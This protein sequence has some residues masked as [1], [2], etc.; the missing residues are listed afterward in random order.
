[1][2]ARYGFGL[3]A[4]IIFLICPISGPTADETPF[5]D[6][7]S[8][9]G[10]EKETKRTLMWSTNCHIS[11]TPIYIKNSGSRD[12]LF[13][14]F[15]CVNLWENVSIFVIGSGDGWIY[16][17]SSAGR[18]KAI[19]GSVFWNLGVAPIKVYWNG[20][21][22]KCL[23]DVHVKGG[24]PPG[25]LINHLKR[26]FLRS[27]DKW[28]FWVNLR[29]NRSDPGTLASIQ[30]LLTSLQ[31][32]A[33]DIFGLRGSI[34]ELVGGRDGFAEL[35]GRRLD[36]T[37]VAITQNQETK[38]QRSVGKH[39]PESSFIPRQYLRIMCPVLLLLFYICGRKFLECIL[40]G[41]GRIW[42]VYMVAGP[43]FGAAGLL[44]FLFGF[45]G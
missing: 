14:R 26:D 7:L 13:H 38:G 23:V 9:I 37:E 32:T 35:D 36:L 21:N 28:G 31:S 10:R 41:C 43:V 11:K 40:N 19:A 29:I 8:F 16:R 30:G 5:G 45:V 27:S 33:G 1:M 24:F 42:Y 25:V 34:S 18:I 12:K 22:S 3:L 17:F 15:L 6:H 2:R 4:I 20:K 39:G 44:A